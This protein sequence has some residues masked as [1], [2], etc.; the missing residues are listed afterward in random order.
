MKAKR[1]LT[2]AVGEVLATLQQGNV[3]K[4]ELAN[5]TAHLVATLEVFTDLNFTAEEQTIL[6]NISAKRLSELEKKLK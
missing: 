5:V 6:F 4:E 2:I 1:E 3:A